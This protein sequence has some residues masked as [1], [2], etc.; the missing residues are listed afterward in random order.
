M[1]ASLPPQ[2]TF[3]WTSLPS[4]PSPPSSTRLTPGCSLS[5]L[6]SNPSPGTA[7]AA[8]AIVLVTL[9][10]RAAFIP[11]GVLQVRAEVSRRRLAPKIAELRKRFGKNPEALQ[12][13][14]LELYQEHGVSPFAGMLPALAQVPIVS[15]LYGVAVSAQLNGHPNE[16]L[17]E[18][19][20]GAPLGHSFTTLLSSPTLAVLVPLALLLVMGGRRVV[21]ETTD[22]A[23]V[24]G[25][26]GSRRS[27]CRRDRH[28]VV[29]V[30]HDGAHRRI[31]AARRRAVPHGVGGVDVRGTHDPAVAGWGVPSLTLGNPVPHRR[32]IDEGPRSRALGTG[33]TWRRRPG[34]LCGLLNPRGRQPSHR[35][36]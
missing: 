27:A 32:V 7:A 9:A 5:P 15:V 30:V 12:R 4:R 11:L 22:T 20:F 24:G 6:C 36:R 16:L 34:V 1:T 23:N 17:G 33:G 25:R 19:L 3:P 10:V 21:H 26:P 14:T 31:R 13:K 2:R 8:L 29:V 28:P 35:P 18:T